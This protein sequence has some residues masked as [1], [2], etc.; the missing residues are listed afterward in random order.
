MFRGSNMGTDVYTIVT[1]RI[2]QAIQSTGTVPWRKPWAGDSTPLSFTSGKPYRGVNRLMLELSGSK[3]RWW[4][5]FNQVNANGGMIRKGEK[6]NIIVFW[7]WLQDKKDPNKRIPFLRYTNVWS[8]DQVDGIEP[9]ATDEV[10]TVLPSERIAAAQAVVDGWSGPTISHGAQGRCF[11]R[12]ATDSI[13]MQPIEFFHSAEEY[14]STL[15][16]E[17]VHSTGHKSRLDRINPGASEYAK[18]EL[19]AEIGAQF[20]CAHVGIDNTNMGDN[21]IAYLQG[22]LKA[23][24]NDS[25]MIVTAASQAEHAVNMILNRKSETETTE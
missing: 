12:P 18:E 2:I 9:P 1:D 3:S 10:R 20:L 17:L 23:L 21:S 14:H 19:I 22:W 6:S 25:R 8:L 13:V 7:K 11:Y 16:H 4:I 15:F 24:K 5:T